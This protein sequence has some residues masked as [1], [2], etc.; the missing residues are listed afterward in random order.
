MGHHVLLTKLSIWTF[1]EL[2]RPGT[3][4]NSSRFDEVCPGLQVD[5]QNVCYMTAPDEQRQEKSEKTRR[6]ETDY[7]VRIWKSEHLFGRH[8]EIVIL[9]EGMTYRLRQTRNG[10]LILHK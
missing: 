10:K 3:G 2:Y 5:S 9:H 7:A 8:P 6:S 4:V 1:G